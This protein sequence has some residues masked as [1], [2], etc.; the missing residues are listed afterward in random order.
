MDHK[1]RSSLGSNVTCV[2]SIA[3]RISSALHE[4]EMKIEVTN[5]H[6]VE[7]SKDKARL[8][9]PHPGPENPVSN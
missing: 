2:L 6:Y 5:C 4:K 8:A 3:Y 9:G 7:Y 1:G